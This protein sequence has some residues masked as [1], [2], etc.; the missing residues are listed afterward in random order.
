MNRVQEIIV[1]T[2]E[3]DRE[4]QKLKKE[5]LIVKIAPRLYTTAKHMP[6]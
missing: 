1:G 2:K 3:K 6:V 5:D 4:I